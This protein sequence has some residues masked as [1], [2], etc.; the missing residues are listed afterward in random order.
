MD[1]RFYREHHAKK[2]YDRH[3]DSEHPEFAQWDSR[4]Q[5]YY[6]VLVAVV[7]LLFLLL[8]GLPSYVP[9]TAQPYAWFLL[10]SAVILSIIVFG[11]AQ[12]KKSGFRHDW[13]KNH[14]QTE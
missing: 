14:P 4:I 9:S 7:G 11:V 10:L 8:F 6:G 3:V 5:R 12:K 2:Y 13:S 1:P